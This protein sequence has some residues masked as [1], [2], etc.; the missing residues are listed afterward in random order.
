MKKQEILKLS[1]DE[2][3]Q[4]EREVRS[5]VTR[6]GLEDLAHS[7]K[8]Y[9]VL[10]P[11]LVEKRNKRYRIIAGH[12]RYLASQM[13]G[14]VTIPSILTKIPKGHKTF[15]SLHENMMREDVNHL[16]LARQLFQ[17]KKE[18]ALADQEIGAL[19]NRTQPWVTMHLRLLRTD[20]NIQAAV[21]AGRINYQGALAL[22]GHPDPTRRR[23]LLEVA[24]KGGASD[25]Q[26]KNWVASEK[27]EG[28]T[29]SPGF[30]SSEVQSPPATPVPLTFKCECCG[31]I[32]D[33][34]DEVRL[35]LDSECYSDVKQAIK[36]LR[37]RMGN[38][39]D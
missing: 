20:E 24:V 14:K 29:P 19:F 5:V 4:P 13:V 6:E 30:S 15:A 36:V 1:L 21:E 7:I 2:I 37:D 26:I 3:D 16:D 25:Q 11:I 39:S 22:Q 38:G 35:R 32:T 17:L 8:L 10:Q 9:G 28:I 31:K 34:N 27:A 33:V 12:R 23:V 18:T